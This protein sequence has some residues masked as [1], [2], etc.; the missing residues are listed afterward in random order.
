MGK[1]DELDEPI[2]HGVPQ[3]DQGQ[4]RPRGKTINDLLNEHFQRRH[5]GLRSLSFHL[6]CMAAL[7][8]SA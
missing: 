3:S 2:D 5:S 6:H 7:M 4:V 8:L 1:V